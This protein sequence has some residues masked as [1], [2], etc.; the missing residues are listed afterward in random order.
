MMNQLIQKEVRESLLSIRFVATLIFLF[1]LL[2]SGALI[3][4]KKFESQL[5]DYRTSQL[6]E[7]D[8]VKVANLGLQRI[9]QTKFPVAKE[10]RLSLF[11]ASGNETRYPRSIVIT[12]AVMGRG[13]LF[14]STDFNAQRQ[15]YLLSP[16]QEFDIVFIVGVVLSFLAIVLG[17]DAISRDREQGTL[18]LQLSN[19]VPR[20]RILLAK[21]FSLLLLLLIPILLG[22]LCSII[23]VQILVGQNLLLLFPAESLLNMLLG[24][25]YISAFVWFSLW[26]SS[27][28]SK[29][30]TA[31]AVLLLVW[32]FVALL[33]PYLGGMLSPRFHPIE[34]E[35]D[36]QRRFQ[37]VILQAVRKTPP[38]ANEVM[39]GK[40]KEQD[41]DWNTIGRGFDELEQFLN[42]FFQGH[43]N[44]LFSQVEF[45]ETINFFSPY[46]AYRQAAEALSN[47]GL[48]YHK[49][50]ISAAKQYRLILKEY[51]RKED[52]QDPESKHRMI[53][54]PMLTSLSKKPI[55]PKLVPRFACPSP[56]V[57]ADDAKAAAPSIAYLCFLNVVL[58]FLALGTFAQADV[59]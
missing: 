52:L 48:P 34:S 40:T 1:I 46:G 57:S 8:L 36:F 27:T 6:Q 38:Q 5:E 2:I 56:R 49:K 25:L 35:G 30:S 29:P 20:S 42:D 31:L 13:G 21:Y 22:S 10:P 50:F 15:N 33:T 11:F 58:F 12:P 3:F 32:A 9:Y 43:L 26:L 41:A 4:S 47:T 44:E 23:L 37:A 18:R 59:R 14:S 17:F 45:A 28:F 53:W 16:Y 24:F 54:H 51:I 7:E 55:D 19:D 39:Q